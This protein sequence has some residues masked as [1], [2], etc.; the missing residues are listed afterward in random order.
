MLTTLLLRFI[1]KIITKFYKQ[2]KNTATD[3]FGSTEE[4][5][6]LDMLLSLKNKHFGPGHGHPN[7]LG[8]EKIAQAL[9]DW[10]RPCI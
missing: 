1:Q 8:H 10:L 5:V 4:F 6:P 9:V 3:L 7:Q 2:G